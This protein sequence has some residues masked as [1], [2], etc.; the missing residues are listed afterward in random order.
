MQQT[1]CRWAPSLGDL[2]G[3]YSSHIKVYGHEEV[4]GTKPYQFSYNGGDPTVFFGM[5][6]L[7]DYL[8]LWRHWGKAWV[9]WTGSDLNNL[10]NGFVFNDGKLKWLSMLFRGVGWVLPILRKAEHYVENEDEANK[11]K[12][13]GITAKI[14]PSFM[15]NV[16]D[17]PVS[18]V[19]KERPDVYVSGHPDREKE[20]G[21]AYV[22]EIAKQVPECTFHLYGADWKSD[23]PNVVCHGSVPKEQ[24]NKDIKGYQ[25]GLRL[26]RSDGFSEITAKS[27]LMG[28]WPITYL[29]YPEIDRFTNTD[30]LV[31]LLK[32][33]KY[34]LE[35]NY[36]G[37][38]WYLLALNQYP[39]CIKR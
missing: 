29:Y 13:F 15:G 38:A 26:N 28:Q 18:Y 17:F 24:F 32:Q 2:E 37:R 7:R 31:A 9:L 8:A 30:E 21:F 16:N 39:W 19:W 3:S 5:Y 25:C 10:V 23:L 20:Y 12:R 14:V 33:L 22:E 11:L 35:P 27:V 4:W 34:K 6:D 36:N 1:Y